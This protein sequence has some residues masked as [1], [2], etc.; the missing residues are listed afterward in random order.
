MGGC[1]GGVVG[2]LADEG[3][4]AGEGAVLGGIGGAGQAGDGLASG[5]REG[6][7]VDDLGVEALE[8]GGGVEVVDVGLFGTVSAVRRWFF[9]DGAMESSGECDVK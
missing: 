3:V 9:S 6:F 2:D 5:V 7:E 8:G 1:G 4:D